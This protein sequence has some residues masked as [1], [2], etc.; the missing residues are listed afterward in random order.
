VRK[1]N[2]RKGDNITSDYLAMNPLDKVPVLIVDGRADRKRRHQYLYRA[3]LPGG[4]TAPVQ[5]NG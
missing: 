3:D 5:F 1:I 2:L 4:Q